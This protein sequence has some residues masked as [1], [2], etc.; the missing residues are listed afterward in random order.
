MDE[1]NIRG[2]IESQNGGRRPFD[3]GAA[4]RWSPRLS[5]MPQLAFL[6]GRQEMTFTLDPPQT[7]GR[8]MMC[9]LPFH[10]HMF[11]CVPFSFNTLPGFLTRLF[12]PCSFFCRQ[13]TEKTPT[14]VSRTRDAT[15]RALTTDFPATKRG[16]PVENGQLFHCGIFQYL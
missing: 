9:G 2:G 16:N 11:V 4:R 10:A 8:W 6:T 3:S 14:F 5:E 15:G 1:T 7:R 13:P 12:F